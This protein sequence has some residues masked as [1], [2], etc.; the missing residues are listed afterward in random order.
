MSYASDEAE[1]QRAL[2]QSTSTPQ[3]LPS[4]IPTIEI[5]QQYLQD[6]MN[7][8]TQIFYDTQ[9]FLATDNSKLAGIGQR[10]N[11]M[12]YDSYMNIQRE[13]QTYID[14]GIPADIIA[15]A[16]ADNVELDYTIA[17]ALAPPSDI[18]VLFDH[19][20]EQL[21]AIWTQINQMLEDRIQ[22]LEDEFYG[23]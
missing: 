18:I 19:T 4:D 20:L 1:R 11:D 23:R 16:I 15:Q 17:V 10:Y 9:Q 8:I 12:V 2:A 21:E 7:K 22:Q 6:F 3:P 13:I 14:S 5:G